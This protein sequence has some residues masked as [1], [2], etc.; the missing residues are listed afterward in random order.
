[1]QKHKDEESSYIGRSPT[2]V[3]SLSELVRKNMLKRLTALAFYSYAPTCIHAQ[4][5]SRCL[6]CSKIAGTTKHIYRI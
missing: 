3:F 5:I 1:M 6:Y 2:L 4:N